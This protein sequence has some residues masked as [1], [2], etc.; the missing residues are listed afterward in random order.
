[1]SIELNKREEKKIIPEKNLIL[2]ESDET[3]DSCWMAE[4][5]TFSTSYQKLNPKGQISTPFDNENDNIRRDRNIIN[6]SNPFLE[7]AFKNEPYV[8]SIENDKSRNFQRHD[9]YPSITDN[10]SMEEANFFNK[11]VNM[12]NNI[13][14]E[15]QNLANDFNSDFLILDLL[16]ILQIYTQI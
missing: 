4:S 2:K 6:K 14:S 9:H 8:S 15:S 3:M 12:K 5:E 7:E 1:M 13:E 10:L 11:F 16:K